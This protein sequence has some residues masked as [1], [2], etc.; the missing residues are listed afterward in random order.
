MIFLTSDIHF[1]HKNVIGFC[2]RPF[3]DVDHMN[4]KL[5]KNWNEVIGIDDVVYIIGDISFTGIEKTKEILRRLNGKKHVIKG[6]HD[7]KEHL[8]ILKKEYLILN[9]QDYLEVEH[10]GKLFILF[11]Y[12]IEEWHWM[13]KG[14]IHLHGHIH[15]GPTKSDYHSITK[16]ENRYDVGVDN[17]NYYPISI[18]DIIKKLGNKT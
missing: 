16:K 7:K 17:N 14:T 5:I 2:N 18:E 6:N 1:G 8:E 4:E 15:S 11:H 9:Y 12:P 13:Q 3:R 10:N